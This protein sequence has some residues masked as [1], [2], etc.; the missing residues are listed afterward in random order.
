MIAQEKK[1]I[2]DINVKNK[3]VL[4][5]VDFN[6]PVKDGNITDD[7]RIRISLPT[8]DYIIENKG[9]PVLLSHFGRPKGKMDP[10]FSLKI[11]ADYLIEKFKYNLLF[12]EDFINQSPDK[13]LKEKND[14][15][16]ILLENLRFYSEEE[17]NNEE[18]AKAL[19]KWGD[20]Y[21]NDAFSASHRAHTSI[22]KL[23]EL[24]E[25]RV[26]GFSLLKEIEAFR[27]LTGSPKKPVLALLGGAKV[28]DKVPIIK[29]LLNLV[30]IFLIGGGM[31]N[32]FLFING[33]GAGSSKLDD[34]AIS[35]AKEIYK[36]IKSENKKFELPDDVVVADTLDE[37]SKYELFNVFEIPDKGYL[38]DIGPKTARKYSE[39]IQ[40]SGTVIFNGTMGVFESDSFASGTKTVLKALS[41]A[42]KKGIITIAGGGETVS[43]INKFIGENELT[44]VSS[45]GGAFLELISGK[46]LPGLRIIQDKNS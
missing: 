20:I 42:T 32:V 31:A 38:L 24:L 1:S 33:F 19:A 35:S 30:D 36:I 40:N 23:P 10:Q 17:E 5:R 29:N 45:G 11:V 41:D 13:I 25:T 37:N 8:I 43:A 39:Y 6:V 15:N 46:D 16:V 2:K 14:F 7:K 44:H 22:V 12:I 4:V 3:K 34:E 9:L 21:V 18:F 28:S 27:L 26:A